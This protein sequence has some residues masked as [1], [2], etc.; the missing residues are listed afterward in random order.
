MRDDGR[1]ATILL[2]TEPGEYSWDDLVR[3]KRTTWS[4]VAN[5]AAQKHMR[6]SAK[7]DEALIYHT[8]DEKRIVGL[9]VLASDPYPDPEDETGKRVVF[10][11]KPARTA[12]SP[13]GATLALIKADARFK[14]FSLVKQARLSV[15]PVPAA[16]DKALRK[17]AGL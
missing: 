7:G 11:L 9:A 1:M 8:G 6:E 15:M 14:D 4:G 17:M 2:K 3:E 5:N 12:K 10:D 16:I 13:D